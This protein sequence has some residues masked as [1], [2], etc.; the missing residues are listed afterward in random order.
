VEAESPGLRDE[1]KD[2]QNVR[3]VDP[4]ASPRPS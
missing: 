2:R 1:G 4:V 3:P